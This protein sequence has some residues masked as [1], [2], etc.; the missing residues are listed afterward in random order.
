MSQNVRRRTTPPHPAADGF[1][2]PGCRDGSGRSL[3]S[4]LSSDL[5]STLTLRSALSGRETSL[6]WS[7]PNFCPNFRRLFPLSSVNTPLCYLSVSLS[8]SVYGAPSVIEHF[9]TLKQPLPPLLVVT[10]DCWGYPCFAKNEWLVV[11][12][13]DGNGTGVSFST[14]LAAQHHHQSHLLQQH[15]AQP[16]ST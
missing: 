1:V 13:V 14:W 6:C 15:P 4:P 10:C 8:L 5:R 7:N 12:A 11:V 16:T 3:G 2:V 9:P